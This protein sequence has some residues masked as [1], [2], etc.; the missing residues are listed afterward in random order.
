L[1]SWALLGE[2]SSMPPSLITCSA[3]ENQVKSSETTC[4]HCGAGVRHE[5]N[6]PSR[7]ATAAALGLTAILVATGCEEPIASPVYGVAT[8]GPGGAGGEGGAGGSGGMGGAAGGG[9]M[10]GMGG[11]GGQG[12]K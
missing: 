4:P 10:A 1:T 12:G 7:S 9:G 3:C 11:M 8:T 2:D 5:A 6:R